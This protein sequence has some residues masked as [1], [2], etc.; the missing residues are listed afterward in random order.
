M[1]PITHLE[2]AILN[3]GKT[4]LD[5][6]TKRVLVEHGHG[7]DHYILC[8]TY[9]GIQPHIT[10]QREDCAKPSTVIATEAARFA[11]IIEGVAA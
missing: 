2:Q 3:G 8:L 1:N 4:T 7:G 5:G 10:A 9:R 6:I 11:R